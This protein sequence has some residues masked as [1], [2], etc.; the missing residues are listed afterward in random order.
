M[1]QANRETVFV[2]GRLFTGGMATSAPLGLLVRGNRVAHVGDD[3]YLREIAPTAE[4]I[5]LKGG[6][7]APSFTDAHLHP[8]S[9]GMELEQCYLLHATSRDDVFGRIAAYAQQHPDTEWILGGGWERELFTDGL[10]TRQQLDAVTGGRPAFLHAADHHGALANT[11]ALARAGVTGQTTSPAGGHIVL[12]ADGN[13]TG[14][15]EENAVKL[16]SRIAPQP[17]RKDIVNGILRAQDNLLELGVTG[18]QDALVGEGL[19]LADNLDAYVEIMERDLLKAR[20]T[21]NLWWE[22]TRGVEQIGELHSRRDRLASI[23]PP[24]RMLVD[25]VKIM[26]D[27]TGHTFF[28]D[29]MLNEAIV[30]AQ[31]AG[32]SAHIHACTDRAVHRALNGIE[33]ARTA[34]TMRRFRYQISHLFVVQRRDLHRFAQLDAFANVQA[35]WG[36]EHPVYELFEHPPL[37]DDHR[38]FGFPCGQLARAGAPLAAGS[39]WPVSSVDP[40]ESL[41]MVTRHSTPG[42]INETSRLDLATIMT[43]YTTGS[44]QAVG[45]GDLVGRLTSGYL[46]DLITF[47]ADPFEV[48]AGNV[49]V[50]STWMDGV[51]V[52]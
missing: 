33:K 35:I 2:G 37:D 8:S 49:K 41:E 6:L 30:A 7:V 13:P 32:F 36:I 17:T 28:D 43:A 39:D 52:A 10:P 24:D 16:L 4:V 42:A 40:V 26:I 12:D 48:G 1:T 51:Q 44:A 19:G 22:P 20:V 9:G 27:G 46:A 23:L 47:D 38:Q 25:T 18:W 31:H 29:D 5:D 11:E 34:D 14:M 50:N 15:L 3:A 21:A 45:R